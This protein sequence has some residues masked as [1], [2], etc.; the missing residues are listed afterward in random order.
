MWLACCAKVKI[1][2]LLHLLPLSQFLKKNTFRCL[3]QLRL[4]GLL[5]YQSLWVS[6]CFSSA[7]KENW[8][9]SHLFQMKFNRKIVSANQCANPCS[10]PLW[11]TACSRILPVI[12]LLVKVIRIFLWVLIEVTGKKV[13]ISYFPKRY[14]YV[15][16]KGDFALNSN[17][18]FLSILKP[19]HHFLHLFQENIFPF[20]WMS[21]VVPLDYG[22]FT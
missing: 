5:S 12:G 10:R 2:L 17:L 6:L 21:S 11:R 16:T 8:Y 20:C 15:K 19:L 3:T 4:K 7:R 22:I 18:T 1:R 14:W 9:K 13:E